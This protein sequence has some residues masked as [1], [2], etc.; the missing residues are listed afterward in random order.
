MKKKVASDEPSRL[1]K[2]SYLANYGREYD[3]DLDDT[4]W[5]KWLLG[6]D[7]GYRLGKL[8]ERRRLKAGGR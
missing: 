4:H 7:A 5:W 2:D 1:A 6:F 8:D 3:S